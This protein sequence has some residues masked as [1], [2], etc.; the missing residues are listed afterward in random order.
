MDLT[1][2]QETIFAKML[3]LFTAAAG[4]IAVIGVAFFM[5]FF[6]FILIAQ[7]KMSMKMGE[8]GWV[9]LIPFYNKFVLAKHAFGNGWS[10]FIILIPFA[11]IPWFFMKVFQGFGLEKIPALLLGLLAAPI[12]IILYGFNYA[13]WQGK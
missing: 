6:I 3:G 9:A 4:V 5:A 12:G 13:P 8:P 1:G 7:C 11:G 10:M 2:L